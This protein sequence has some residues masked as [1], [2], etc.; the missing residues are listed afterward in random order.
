MNP[1]LQALN[2]NAP[3]PALNNITQMISQFAQFKNQMQGRN[4]QAIVQNLLA[5]GQMSQSQFE[6]L[7]Q[8]AQ[9]L[10]SILK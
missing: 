10:Q 8:Q 2:R 4:P 7:K 9:S 3:Q 1:I 5:S 6:M